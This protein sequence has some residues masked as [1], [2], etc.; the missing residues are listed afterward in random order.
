[1]H[2]RNY[3]SAR[4]TQGKGTLSADDT[5][6]LSVAEAAAQRRKSLLR[7]RKIRH[8]IDWAKASGELSVP[9]L[10]WD[11][12]DADDPDRA[13]EEKIIRKAR[14]PSLLL[15]AGPV[16]KQDRE[17]RSNE[18]F[19]AVSSN[20]TVDSLWRVSLDR[21]LASAGRAGGV[22]SGRLMRSAEPCT[23]AP[24][25]ARA[26]RVLSRQLCSALWKPRGRLQQG[27]LRSI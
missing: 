27:V 11:R 17:I 16:P 15:A 13:T 2:N 14:A 20:R 7:E 23:G 22:L 26:R 19:S 12:D 4:C 9:S 18:G 6:A 1:M 3:F 25:V 10:S 5:A 8:L 24:L 21:W